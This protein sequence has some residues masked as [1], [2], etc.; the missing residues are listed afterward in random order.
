[1]RFDRAEADRTLSALGKRVFLLHDI[2][3][4]APRTFQTRWSMS[5]LRGPLSRDQIRTL[6][7][8]RRPAVA[9]PAAT[10]ARGARQTSSRHRAGRDLRLPPS[11]RP[12]SSSSSCR[13][14]HPATPTSPW[15]SA[16]RA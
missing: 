11:S 8:S 10:A 15:R 7:S 9:A 2:H 14:R 3:E 6:M 5:Y 16:P 1:M 12:V 13:A 4:E